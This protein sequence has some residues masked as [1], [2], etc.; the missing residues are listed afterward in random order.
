MKHHRSKI[1]QA[2]PADTLVFVGRFC[3]SAVPAPFTLVTHFAKSILQSFSL[4]AIRRS[5]GQAVANIVFSFPQALAMVPPLPIIFPLFRALR[6]YSRYIW[7]R[8]LNIRLPALSI[9]TLRGD[10]YE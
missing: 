3:V 4:L 7:Y 8:N 9:D 10:T 5:V 1:V 6:G 2:S